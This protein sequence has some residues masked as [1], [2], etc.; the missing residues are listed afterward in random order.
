ME[1]ARPPERNYKCEKI[2]SLK[3]KSEDIWNFRFFFPFLFFSDKYSCARVHPIQVP[4]C[5]LILGHPCGKW[6]C[7]ALNCQWL[8]GILDLNFPIWV[9]LKM[10]DIW[11]SF[12][13]SYKGILT[14]IFKRRRENTWITINTERF[15]SHYFVILCN[16]SL[17][18]YII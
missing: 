2:W 15:H 14:W 18:Q 3:E 6:R 7:L 10:Y 16:N 9:F 17:C 12:L 8:G 11:V 1:Q 4:G 13:F 5:R